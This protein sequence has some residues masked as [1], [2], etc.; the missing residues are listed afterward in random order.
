M[1]EEHIDYAKKNME[2]IFN[3]LDAGVITCIKSGEICEANKYA[4]EMFGFGEKALK[5]MKAEQLFKGFDIVK[6]CILAKKNYIG[7]DVLV[8]TKKNKLYYNLSAYPILDESGAIIQFILVFREMKRVRKLTGKILSSRAIYTFDKIIGINKDFINVVDY[9]KRISDSKST[10]LIMGESGSGKEVFAQSIHNQSNRKEEAFVAVNCS[11]IP[12]TLIESELFGYEEGSFTGARHG[13][14][15]GKFEIAD[16]GTIFL[17]EIGDMPVDMQMKLLRV[18]EENLIVRIGSVNPIPIDVRIIAAT[19]RNLFDDVNKGRF[20]KDLYYRLNVLPIYLPPLR[21]RVDDI[22]F[23]ADYFMKS[24][25]KR[26]NKKV[27]EMPEEYMRYLMDYSWPGN[28]R[29]LENIIELIINTQTLCYSLWEKNS[30]PININ[31]KVEEQSFNLQEI[32]KTTIIKALLRFNGKIS[33]AA[34]SLGVARN[35]LYRKMD[36]YNIDRSILEQRSIMEQKNS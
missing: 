1:K 24:I 20:R 34:K 4:I 13:G 35:T 27:V 22:P 26:L 23:L 8:N 21:E 33:E 15:A 30:R 31:N 10:I 18:I 12:R 5:E 25:S 9:S 14:Y 2:T 19:H 29:E 7:E 32:E 17:D 3:S 6:E 36:T 11:A 28:I 16:G